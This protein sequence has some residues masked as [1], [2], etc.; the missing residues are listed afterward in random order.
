MLAA[1]GNRRALRRRNVVEENLMILPADLPMN[2]I[3]RMIAP[4]RH[5]PHCAAIFSVI[6]VIWQKA[7]MRFRYQFVYRNS[8]GKAAPYVFL[9]DKCD[10]FF[11]RTARNAPLC[12][13]L[14]KNLSHFLAL[15]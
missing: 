5:N 2:P 11:A 3:K 15:M 10:N 1:G 9:V 14:D 4:C 8:A 13:V 6:P 12:S 7:V